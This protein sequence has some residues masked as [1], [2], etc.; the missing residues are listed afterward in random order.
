MSRLR[1]SKDEDRALVP[2]VVFVSEGEEVVIVGRGG[3]VV[4]RDSIVGYVL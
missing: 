4:A 3:L 2:W 1:W